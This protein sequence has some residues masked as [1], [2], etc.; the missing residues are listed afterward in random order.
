ML[1]VVELEYCN[2]LSLFYVYCF[3]ALNFFSFSPS[4]LGTVTA[5]RLCSFLEERK[6]ISGSDV[7]LKT[8]RMLTRSVDLFPLAVLGSRAVCGILRRA[9]TFN[10]IK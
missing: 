6:S 3:M 8:F 1:W 7:S 4:I 9:F 5:C 2:V 10:K